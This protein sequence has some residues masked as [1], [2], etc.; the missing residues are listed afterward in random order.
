MLINDLS[1]LSTLLTSRLSLQP[2]TILSLSLGLASLLFQHCH[3]LPLNITLFNVKGLLVLQRFPQRAACSHSEPIICT[4]F[5]LS[6]SA[7][8]CNVYNFEK[9]LKDYHIFFSMHFCELLSTQSEELL[10][11]PKQ[12]IVVCLGCVCVTKV[13]H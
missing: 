13:M 2:E 10:S 5:S 9:H 8:A 1:P 6:L 3:F 12:T 4:F 11:S 7:P